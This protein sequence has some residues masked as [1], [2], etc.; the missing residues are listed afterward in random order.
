MKHT[1]RRIFVAV[2]LLNG[3][4][5]IS[6]ERIEMTLQ[7]AQDYAVKNAFNTKSAVFDAEAAKYNTA[8]LKAIGLPQINGSAQYNQYF[9]VPYSIIPPGPFGPEATRIRFVNP[10]SVTIGATAS[11]LLFDGTWLVAL[12]AAK[13]YEQ[14]QSENVKKSAIE[15]KSYVANAYYLSLISIENSRLIKEAKADMVFTLGQTKAILEAGF[16]ESENV[17][18]LQLAVNDLDIQ[19]TYSDEQAKLTNDLLK[20]QMGL[21]LNTELVL[22]DNL[23]A[24]MEASSGNLLSTVFIPENNIDVQIANSGLTLQELNLKV[25][26]AAYLPNLSAFIN[27]QT[28]AYRQRF[29][30]FDSAQPYLYGNLLGVQMNVPILSGGMRKNEVKK[31]EVEVKRM[32]ETT[33]LARKASELEFRAARSELSNALQSYS[34]TKNSL[35]LAKSILNKSQIKF[36]EGLGTSFDVTQRNT[37]L[38]QTQGAYIQSMMKVLHATTRLSKALNQL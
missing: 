25:K 12:Q 3:Y 22:T 5:G 8:S 17:D 27:F 7:Q 34:S 1:V 24:F 6:Q 30:F 23:D 16:T 36:K 4:A 38:I 33:N 21:P 31:V 20:F 29:D 13:S 15:V 35:D 28:A 18:Q 32:E 14:F 19:I 37:Q 10:Y 11:Q 9:Y 2:I 26:K